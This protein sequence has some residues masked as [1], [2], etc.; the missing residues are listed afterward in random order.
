MAPLIARRPLAAAAIQKLPQCLRFLDR[1][2][3][4]ASG[5]MEILVEL[6][7]SHFTYGS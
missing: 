1:V 4:S 5:T 3:L 2:L 7:N 6:E